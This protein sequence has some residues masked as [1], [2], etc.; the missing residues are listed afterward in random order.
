VGGFFTGLFVSVSASGI[1][2]GVEETAW[3]TGLCNKQNG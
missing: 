3:V 1:V 2:P